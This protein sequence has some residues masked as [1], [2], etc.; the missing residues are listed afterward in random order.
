MAAAAR[1]VVVPELGRRAVAIAAAADDEL[2][3]DDADRV[4]WQGAAVARLTR[5]RELRRPQLAIL[6]GDDL[7]PRS[8][9]AGA[10]RVSA[11]LE[12]WLASRLAALDRLAAAAA[13]ERLGGPARGIAF[14]LV[15]RM[16]TL[17]RSHVGSL[18]AHL[19]LEG[20]RA[21]TSLGVRFGRL[22]L[23]LPDLLKPAAVEARVRL[24]RIAKEL[25]LMLPAAGRIVL[26]GE[27][28]AAP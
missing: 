11:W 25:E 7:S 2:A 4:V 26:R 17:E 15:E 1:K 14:S 19:D 21:L 18:L 27:A 22:Y 24:W 9:S 12:G 3:L 10:G 16:G 13:S 8:R 20:H 5:G 28:A 23:Y 6:A